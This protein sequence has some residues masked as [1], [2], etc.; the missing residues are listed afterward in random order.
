M[1]T[2][3]ILDD[4]EKYLKYL[5]ECIKGVHLTYP[6]EIKTYDD[7]KIFINEKDSFPK[8]SIFILDLVLK[9]TCGTALANEI[10]E[11]YPNSA[12]IFITAF[13]EKLTEIVDYPYCYFIYKPE[14]SLRLEKAIK[15]AIS[16]YERQSIEIELKNKTTVI[17]VHDLMYIEHGYRVSKL[18]TISTIYSEYENISSYLNILPCNYIQC[19]KSFI[20]NLDFVKEHHRDE[21]I[22]KNGEHIQISRTFS[23]SARN[24]FIEYIKNKT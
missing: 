9:D 23:K 10:H 1:L 15:K 4:D 11:L 7:E 5:E 20:V 3:I 19:H 14:L 17:S 8:Q 16:Y 21:F 24:A 13:L 22:L 6:F 2:L 18:H 12:I